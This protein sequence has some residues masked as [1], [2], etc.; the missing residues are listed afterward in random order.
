MDAHHRDVNHLNLT[1]IG[2]SRRVHQ[3][4][5]H[6]AALMPRK[7][8]H[9]AD[10]RFADDTRLL[11]I[12]DLLDDEQRQRALDFVEAGGVAVVADPESTLHGGAGPGA[13]RGFTPAR[14]GVA[15]RLRSV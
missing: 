6:A 12:A 10:L 13:R 5:R 11:V 9:P 2:L 7:H 3:P 15:A 14:S 8:H 1:V 4:A